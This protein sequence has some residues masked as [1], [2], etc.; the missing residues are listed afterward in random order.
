MK[1]CKF[2]LM[3]LLIPNF[4]WVGAQTKVIAHR[5][6]SAIAP[7]NT[8][9]AFQK[10]IA[11]GA[12]YLELDVRLTKDDS[13][14][15]IHD[16]SVDRT[17]SNNMKAKVNEMYFREIARVKAGYSDKFDDQYSNEKIPTLREVLTM[18]K[19]KI[20]VAIELKVYGAENEVIN[21]VNQL[22]V[23]DQ[24]IIFSFYYPV[25]AKIRQLDKDIPTLYLI[26]KVDKLTLD[27]AGVID[28][29]AIGFHQEAKVDEELL[30]AAHRAN[31]ELW[32][33]TVN[34]E[35]KM[36]EFIDLGIDG[37]ISDFPDKAIKLT[38]N[39][40]RKTGIK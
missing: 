32:V 20:K 36:K 7:E 38:N 39:D 26:P 22:G 12:D 5:G 30:K 9:A 40:F 37:L 27:Y 25:L 21:L 10:A 28:A 2:I 31:M 16:E 13:L 29:N 6:F 3:S 23:A 33:W 11:I 8:L 17:S 35:T 24:V 19:D 1:I 4:L 15:V 14:V 18:T 34:N